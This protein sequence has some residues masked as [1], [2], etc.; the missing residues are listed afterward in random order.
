MPKT[1]SD[2]TDDQR[3]SMAAWADRW[4][5]NSLSTEPANFKAA[6][7]ACLVAYKLA[8][9]K[10]PK[11]ILHVASPYAAI[12][13]GAA[14]VAALRGPTKK[15]ANADSTVRSQVLTKVKDQIFEQTWPRIE[16]QIDEVSAERARVGIEVPVSTRGDNA[17]GNPLRQQLRDDISALYG[18][19]Q[20]E[21]SARLG[22][23]AKIHNLALKDFEALKLAAPGRTSDWLNQAWENSFNGNLWSSWAAYVTFFRDACSWED[24]I[25]ERFALEEAWQVNCGWIWWHEDVLVLSDRPSVVGLDEENR[26]HNEVG[27]ALGYRDG[28]GI[29]AWHGTLLPEHWVTQK[30]TVNP[31][32]IIGCKNVEQRA[33]GAAMVGWPRMIKHLNRKIIDGDPNTDVGA[34]I[35][36]SLP[37]L[38]EP[39]RFLQAVCPRNG[40]IVEG[41]PRVSDIDNRPI[42]TVMAAQAWRVGLPASAYEHPVLRT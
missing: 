21:H 39:G 35:E 6:E 3:N 14:A 42:E 27:P 18:N 31:A 40:I 5:K 11:V 20:K 10:P 8:G 2:L 12:Y 33:A 7:E 34:L 9:Y 19:N 36:L 24:P 29:Y 38:R 15:S 4:V 16:S 25:L 28:W 1:I 37:G 30:D 23:W 26:L 22:N 32:E 13:A 17:I 41:V